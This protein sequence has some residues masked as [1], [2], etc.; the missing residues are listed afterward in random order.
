MHICGWGLAHGVSKHLFPSPKK[1]PC[2]CLRPQERYQPKISQQL[3]ASTPPLLTCIP[4]V[5]PPIYS[6]S[7]WLAPSMKT[8]TRDT[9]SFWIQCSQSDP[10]NICI[11]CSIVSKHKEGTIRDNVVH[12]PSHPASL[13]IIVEN[14][15]SALVRSKTTRHISKNGTYTFSQ[16]FQ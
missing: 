16:Q 4:L 7:P 8:C 14:W 11:P 1:N 12:P 10:S 15:F 13:R 2:C 5:V 3:T 9:P 6:C